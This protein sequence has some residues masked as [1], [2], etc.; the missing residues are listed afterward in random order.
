MLYHISLYKSYLKSWFTISRQH[1]MKSL[2]HLVRLHLILKYQYNQYNLKQESE[3]EF[4]W[5]DKVLSNVCIKSLCKTLCI[6][7]SK[8]G[9][10]F[11]WMNL[12]FFM[13]I[14]ILPYSLGLSKEVANE[15]RSK[16]RKDETVIYHDSNTGSYEALF[17]LCFSFILI[18]VFHSVDQEWHQIEGVVD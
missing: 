18:K 13:I 2:D 15:G 7:N 16:I 4:L 14:E 10:V 5:V 1:L 6:T 12:I 11:D 9:R 3:K 8:E 17:F